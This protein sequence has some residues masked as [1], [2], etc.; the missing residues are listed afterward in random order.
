[1]LN[2]N[3]REMRRVFNEDQNTSS[4]TIKVFKLSRLMYDWKISFTI[5]ND[6]CAKVT[7]L[8]TF[9]FSSSIKDLRMP[10]LD[11]K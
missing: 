6:G 10:N 8:S 9:L 11:F 2:D 3:P 5:V 1:S 4:A 7:L